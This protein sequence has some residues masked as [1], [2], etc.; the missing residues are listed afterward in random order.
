MT[1]CRMLLNVR[2]NVTK[3]R[4]GMLV[5]DGEMEVLDL[6]LLA[7]CYLSCVHKLYVV[8]MTSWYTFLTLKLT[9]TTKRLAA[10]RHNKTHSYSNFP[11]EIKLAFTMFLLL[12]LFLSFLC[13]TFNNPRL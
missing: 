1:L 6:Y 13:S 4:N 5:S 11:S 9:R 8:I 2:S 3:G 7:H 10:A 12:S